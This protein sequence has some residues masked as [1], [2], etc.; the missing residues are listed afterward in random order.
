ML[1]CFVRCFSPRNV[2]SRTVKLTT[3]TNVDEICVRIT[4][5]EPSQKSMILSVYVGDLHLN[6]YMIEKSLAIGY[7]G[8]RKISP[9]NWMNHLHGEV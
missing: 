6:K 4:N 2:F 5:D 9:S 1:D 7:D 3:S 8:G